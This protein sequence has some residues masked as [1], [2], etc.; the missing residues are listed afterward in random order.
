M[1]KIKIANIEKGNPVFCCD[2]CTHTGAWDA[3]DGYDCKV[4]GDKARQT[5]SRRNFGTCP[6]N[7]K[8]KVK[9]TRG[10]VGQQKQKKVR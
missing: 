8:I 9:K 1:E 5:Y 6:L 2:G 10:R 4:Y 3:A 7:Q